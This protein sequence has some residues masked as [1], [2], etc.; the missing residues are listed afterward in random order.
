[1]I[2]RTG[3]EAVA[4][5]LSDESAIFHAPSEM[6]EAVYL[7]ER[8]EDVIQILREAQAARRMVTVSGGGTGITGARVPL[9][10][11][12]VM[13]M[14][15][16]L[17]PAEHEGCERVSLPD[18]A[19]Y[20]NRREGIAHLP[21]GITLQG[22]EA[23]LPREMLYPPDPTEQTAM[24]GGTAATNASGARCFYYGATRR[25]VEGLRVILP[26]GERL[27]LRRGEILAHGRTFQFR[28]EEG[29]DYRLGLPSYDSP[30][31]KNSAGLYVRPGT[32]LVDLFI[33]SEGILGV[34]TGLTVRLTQRRETIS[35]LAFLG[36]EREAMRLVR[37]L[38]G[39]NG[40][41]AIEYFDRYSLDFVREKYPGV[42][43]GAKGAV[44]VEILESELCALGELLKRYTLIE[45]WC[46]QS[47]EDVERL[48]D[49]RHALP[50]R[51]NE[52]LKEHESY[53][54]GTDF[55][56]PAHSFEEMLRRYRAVGER[57]RRLFPRKGVHYVLFGHA[58]DCH[59]HFNFIT[60][61]REELEAAKGL[62]VE[63]ARSAISLG[64]TISGEHGVGKKR[65]VVDGR[66]IPYLE[67]MYNHGTLLEIGAVKKALDPH[68][69]L[70]TG[71]IVPLEYL[72]NP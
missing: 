42:A 26:S 46:A 11:G 65:V 69:I 68:L 30:E 32:D 13:A 14:E 1:M 8:E 55:A 22:L 34:I 27:I 61:S 39:L 3:S 59:L 37:D 53:K 41:L 31:I 5:Y 71:N 25:W 72:R 66:E 43:E 50:E 52:Y 36:G 6:V 12:V 51:V 2:V 23:A 28:T 10:G 17:A 24:L 45:D 40:V 21:P 54:L 56:V 4:G 38:R 18:G 47:R 63:L 16:M 29:G 48:K 67:L 9:H 70:N 44:F 19:I 58:G 15:R 35:D 20:L 49:L 62:Y 33:G 57:F 64:G 60:E 7:P